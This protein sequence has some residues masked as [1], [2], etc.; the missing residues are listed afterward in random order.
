M[1]LTSVSDAQDPDVL[2][3][4]EMLDQLEP[5][6][7]KCSSMRDELKLLVPPGLARDVYQTRADIDIYIQNEERRRL[8][9]KRKN[10]DPSLIVDFETNFHETVNNSI[11]YTINDKTKEAKNATKS[12]KDY[13]KQNQQLNEL[14][15]AAQNYYD[16]D[17]NKLE[18]LE[19]LSNAFYIRKISHNAYPECLSE[20]LSKDVENQSKQVNKLLQ[21]IIDAN[22][23]FQLRRSFGRKFYEINMKAHMSSSIDESE[24]ADTDSKKNTY[25]VPDLTAPFQN[26]SNRFTDLT[27]G[28]LGELKS[29]D[30]DWNSIN[31]T[32]TRIRG[33]LEDLSSQHESA[34]SVAASVQEATLAQLC[35]AD[36][37]QEIVQSTN[38]SGDVGD[39]Q[40]TLREGISRT[41][42]GILEIRS[43][44]K[45]ME[46]M[47]DRYDFDRYV[48]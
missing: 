24:P 1:L 37:V 30:L 5:M 47:Q 40:K 45:E 9:R 13:N 21:D 33:T 23:S 36:N 17:K 39:I 31:D 12:K 44:I 8:F 2:E 34:A 43:A 29:L 16:D 19:K 27:V 10:V 11:K 35:E 38:V 14:R 28:C 25:K 32:A 46:D 48:E 26:L 42:D 7:E 6:I 4:T 3:V 18:N 20:R 41:T 22:N 15:N